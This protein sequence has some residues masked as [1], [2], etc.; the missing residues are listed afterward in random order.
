MEA[1]NGRVVSI[2]IAP[3]R[4]V[5]VT[6][7]LD[8]GHKGAHQAP[9]APAPFPLP[10]AVN[11]SVADEKYSSVPRF[12]L[13][14]RGVFEVTKTSAHGLAL[15]QAAPESE[16]VWIPGPSHPISIIGDWGWSNYRVAARAIAPALAGEWVAVGGL[17]NSSGIGVNGNKP[18]SGVFLRAGAGAWSVVLGT[19]EI[20]RNG[21]LPDERAA[22]GSSTVRAGQ[23]GGVWR[24]L[25]LGF[26]GSG[27]VV[28]EIDGV[29]LAGLTR[30]EIPYKNGWAALGC[31][32]NE[33]LYQTV[34]IEQAKE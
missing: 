32:W 11:F 30:A 24:E 13:D 25:S 33:C 22:A 34:R 12:F 29:R 19:G 1:R 7:Q 10:F 28:A 17:V 27:S 9:P 18:D 16:V 6:S 20:L 8:K 15:R 26:E 14:Q 23:R 21:T 2:S 31:G 3:R 5:T 4:I